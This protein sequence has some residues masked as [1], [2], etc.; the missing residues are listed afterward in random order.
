[1]QLL[2]I[3]FGSFSFTD[4]I[5]DDAT[6]TRNSIVVPSAKP[7]VPQKIRLLVQGRPRCAP[8]VGT[9]DVDL[10]IFDFE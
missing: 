7:V 6:N 4:E 1:M 10:T 2:A 8:Y 3:W 9:I 5:W